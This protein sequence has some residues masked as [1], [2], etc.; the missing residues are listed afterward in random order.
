MYGWYAP[1]PRMRANVGIRRRLAPLLDNSRPEI[2]LIHALLLSLPGSP[3]PL[4]RRRDRHGRQHLAQRPRR[5]AHADAVDP[6]PQRGLL[7]GRPRQALPAGD[8]VARLPLQ[9]RQRRGADGQSGSSLLHWV[10]G[11]LRS[12]ASTPCSGSATSRSCASDN[13]RGPGVRAR[14]TGAS[15]TPRTAGPRRCSASTTCRAARRPTTITAARGARGTGRLVDLFGGSGFPD[16]RRRRHDHHH[17]RVARL[18]LAARWRRGAVTAVAEIHTGADPQPDQ[19][20][21]A[22]SAGWREQR[23]YAAKGQQPAAA[24]ARRLAPRRPGG[25]GGRRDA[26]RSPTRPAPSR[27]STRCPSPTAASRS[28]APTTPSSARW[29]TAC[30]ARRWV[31]DGPHDPVYAAQLLELVQGRVRAAVVDGAPAPSTSR[32]PVCRSRAGAPRCTCAPRGCCP[33]SSPTPRSSSTATC[34]TAHHTPLIVKVFRMLSPRREP[35]RRRA[36]RARRRRLAPGAR[37]RRAR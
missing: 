10:R 23:W 6:R 22:S 26:P 37:G 9:P 24:P 13:E 3:V 33:A 29:S 20:R 8:P 7:H 31:Y 19:D 28:A 18:L 27:S 35:R 4:L 14:S 11:M 21:A 36:G 1:D 17:P 5:R 30:S 15:A 16:D 12:A 25:R 34:P 2:E 32:S